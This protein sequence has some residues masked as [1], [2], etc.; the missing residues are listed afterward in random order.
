MSTAQGRQ[1]IVLRDGAYVR[2][3]SPCGQAQLLLRTTDKEGKYT[4]L[5]GVAAAKMVRTE[6]RKRKKNKLDFFYLLH[7]RS[8]HSSPRMPGVRW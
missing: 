1:R 6:A 3:M 5:E 2:G 7:L 8:L 4:C